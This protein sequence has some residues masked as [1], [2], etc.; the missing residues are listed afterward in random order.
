MKLVSVKN[1]V[2]I[3][4]PKGLLVKLRDSYVGAMFSWS[5][6]KPPSSSSKKKKKNDDGKGRRNAKSRKVSNKT[7]DFD[8]RMMLHIYNTVMENPREPA[9]IS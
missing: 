4:P 5:G 9:R 6:D 3:S 1:K 7:S 2:K 8:K